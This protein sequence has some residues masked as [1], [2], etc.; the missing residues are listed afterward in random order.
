V[1][2]L[3]NVYLQRTPQV[4][5]WRVT[6]E[7]TD[8]DHQTDCALSSIYKSLFTSLILSRAVSHCLLTVCHGT[9]RSAAASSDSMVTI[10]TGGLAVAGTVTVST[11]GLA[12]IG[13]VTIT[14]SGAASSSIITAL[15][16]IS[17]AGTVTNT[18]G[19][20]AVAGTV[21]V[22]SIPQW[23]DLLL[24]NFKGGMTEVCSVYY[25]VTYTV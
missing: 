12:V 2:K 6:L 14:T 16:G 8:T 19:G 10:T 7:V 3:L 17:S 9:I 25:I 24:T 18:T 22:S 23:R 20:L 11:G 15:R 1:F 21:T 4:R 13:D 5:C